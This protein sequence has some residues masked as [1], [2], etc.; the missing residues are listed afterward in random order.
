VVAVD[1][2]PKALG[3]FRLIWREQGP[4]LRKLW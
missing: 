4:K 2:E 1:P 3:A